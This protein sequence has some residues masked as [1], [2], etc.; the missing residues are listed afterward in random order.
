MEFKAHT[1]DAEFRSLMQR[2]RSAG[3]KANTA[4]KTSMRRSTKPIV[5]E[6]KAEAE[7]HKRTGATKRSF[8]TMTLKEGVKI[9]VRYNFKDTKTGKIPN[10]YAAKIIIGK[11]G[12]WFGKI[13]NRHKHAVTMRVFGEVKTQLTKKGF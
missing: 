3:G 2:L 11:Q 5:N 9:G 1:N 4:M 7:M 10:V 8:G 12:D 6:W 13:W